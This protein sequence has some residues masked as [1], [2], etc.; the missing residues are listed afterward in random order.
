MHFF[1]EMFS[2]F[3]CRLTIKQLGL[4]CPSLNWEEYKS[5]IF[6]FRDPFDLVCLKNEEICD[7]NNEMLKDTLLALKSLFLPDTFA[8]LVF[9]NSFSHTCTIQWYYWAAKDNWA[10]R[11]MSLAGCWTRLNFSFFVFC[12]Q[13]LQDTFSM[14]VSFLSGKVVYVSPQGSS[15][16]RCK[17]ECLQGTVFSELLA[18]Q[19]VS[20]FYSSTAPCRLPPWASCMGSGKLRQS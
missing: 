20:T 17:P 18:P 8:W 9:R 3:V 1:A 11:E 4:V 13:S 7:A 6:R 16:L 5:F 19:D 2:F 12:F 14:A 15:L 10:Q